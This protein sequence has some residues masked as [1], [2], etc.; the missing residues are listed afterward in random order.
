[1]RSLAFSTLVLSLLAVSVRAGTISLGSA[2]AFAVLG[3]AGVTNT[4]PSL[5][6]GSLAGST[7]TPAVTGFPPGAVIAPGVLYGAGVGAAIGEPFFDAL[8]AS[9][10]AKGFTPTPEGTSSL[11]AGGLLSLPPGVYS[12]TSSVVLLN[13]LLQL[14]A[15][16]SN[17]ASWTFQIPFALTTASASSVEVVD[18]GSAGPFTGSITWVVGSQATLGTTTTFLGTIISGTASVLQSGATVGCGR[19]ISLTAGVTLDDNIVDAFPADCAV[20]GGGGEG[21]GGPI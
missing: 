7:G 18:T 19:V 11:G 20:T 16:G 13:G 15:L 9:N 14:D 1:M 10:S 8:A 5:I 4:G 2:S 17:N 6:Y 12:F 21:G 3:E